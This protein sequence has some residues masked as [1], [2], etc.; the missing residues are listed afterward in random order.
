[1]YREGEKCP[2]AV[3]FLEVGLTGNADGWLWGM[4]ERG[5]C[6]LGFEQ[7]NGSRAVN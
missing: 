2:D 1:M 5:I 6:S 4:R 7:L 3:Y